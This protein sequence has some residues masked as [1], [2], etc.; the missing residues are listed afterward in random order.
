[1]EGVLAHGQARS[2]GNDLGCA[3]AVVVTAAAATTSL[4]VEPGA[5]LSGAQVTVR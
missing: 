3:D 4:N 2:G 5:S 1:V